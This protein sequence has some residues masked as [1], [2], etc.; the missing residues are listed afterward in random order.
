VRTAGPKPNNAPWRPRLPGRLA[1]TLLLL[2]GLALS[3]CGFQLRGSY[4]V[5]PFL[6]EISLKIPDGADAL[7][8]ELRLA[9]ERNQIA[10]AGGELLLDVVSETLNRQTSSV[11]SSAR[12]AEYTLVYAVEFRLNSSDGRLIGPLESL[13]LRR[14]YQYS[15]SN[16]VGKSTEEETLVQELRMDAAQQIVR[17]LATLRVSPLAASGHEAAAP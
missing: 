6:R 16:I 4:D 14:S 10:T 13:I 15:S 11:D 3:A 7:G 8:R 2:A 1:P 17:Q 12:A 9:L 5:P